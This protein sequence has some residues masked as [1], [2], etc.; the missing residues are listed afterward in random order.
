MPS[1]RS[2]P[3][4]VTPHLRY[5]GW[6]GRAPPAG[7]WAPAGRAAQE[8]GARSSPGRPKSG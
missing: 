4:H 6:G 1:R 8:S 2:S 7:R 5:A 3:G